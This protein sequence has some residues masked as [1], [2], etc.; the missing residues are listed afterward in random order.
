M[1]GVVRHLIKRIPFGSFKERETEQEKEIVR[2]RGGGG[3]GRE[4]E[5][6]RERERRKIKER[7]KNLS[8]YVH[9]QVKQVSILWRWMKKIIQLSSSA[10]VRMA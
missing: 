4:R 6:E 9:Y 7:C 10:E 3:G 1:N 2:R 5:R 8:F